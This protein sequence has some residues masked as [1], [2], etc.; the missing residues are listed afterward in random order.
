MHGK[1]TVTPRSYVAEVQRWTTEIGRLLWAAIQDWMCEPHIIAKTGLS[2]LEHQRRTIASYLELRDL[3]PEVTWVPVVQGWTV[4]DYR[5]HVDAYNDAGVDLRAF[6]TVGVGSVCRRQGT[7]EG[8]RIITAITDL[9][10]KVHAFGV[11]RDGLALF[12]DR[13][14]SADSLAWSYVARRRQ[15]QLPGHTH[16]TCSNCYDFAQQWR[17]ELVGRAENAVSTFRQTEMPWA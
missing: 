16:K 4:D 1:W 10:I 6:G 2:V 8:A 5:A 9:G 13:I 14:A 15:I 7:L 12:Q 3:A 11:K 17:A